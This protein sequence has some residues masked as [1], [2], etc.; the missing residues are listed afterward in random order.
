MALNSKLLT[1]SGNIEILDD[2]Q[3]VVRKLYGLEEQELDA[4]RIRTQLESIIAQLGILILSLQQEEN[5]FL[6][7]LGYGTGE[8]GK[9]EF[10]EA[11]KAFYQTKA[12]RFYGP[13]VRDIIQGYEA[14]SKSRQQETANYF[15]TL[16]EQICGKKVAKVIDGNILEIEGIA[17]D[18][19]IDSFLNELNIATGR[20][21]S[22][23]RGSGSL[24]GSGFVEEVNKD[25]TRFLLNK[26]SPTVKDITNEAIKG[27]KQGNNKN[28]IL[29]QNQ[30]ADK[31]KSSIT[32]DSNN[33]LI[34]LGFEWASLTG[35]ATSSNF[36][37]DL[38]DTNKKIIAQIARAIAKDG[39]EEKIAIEVMES[40]FLSNSNKDDL[41][42]VGQGTTLITGILG[43]IAAVLAIYNL[44]KGNIN[45]KDALGWVATEKNKGKQLSVDMVLKYQGHPIGIQVKNTTKDVNLIHNDILEIGFAQGQLRGN[46]SI[47]K[48]LG[49]ND[50]DE[51]SI[52]SALES[53][54]FN[55][56]YKLEGKTYV[57]TPRS[58]TLHHGV[59]NAANFK[60][61]VDID[62]EIQKVAEQI[63]LF[64]QQFMPDF[65]YMSLGEDATNKLAK[66]EE[67]TK[68]TAARI[69]GNAVYMVADRVAFASDMIQTFQQDLQ[70]LKD[71]YKDNE[72]NTQ[73]MH[74]KLQTSFKQS[75][76]NGLSLENIVEYLNRHG[77]DS[78]S[79]ASYNSRLKSSW[80]FDR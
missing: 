48:K 20:S 22:R 70:I 26:L 43:E 18:K 38:Q 27:I 77:R 78:T 64:F 37:G 56:P 55:V 54:T 51:E 76:K 33:D 74:L 49:F 67:E 79:L 21:T 7:A 1:L 80:G 30:S 9:K 4:Q 2:S 36:S 42:L 68:E 31:L 72:I 75:G 50:G 59:D 13:N 15:S 17:A 16:L 12:R 53:D 58:T 41:F 8:S 71:A 66:L 5:N 14:G 47:L 40:K 24:Y 28:N 34:K 32:I 10:K 23:K 65:L 60:R 69:K 57:Q 39:I 73:T 52:A 45:I 35:G 46:E 44:F 63:H 61:F 11:V 25:T 6:T 19:V 62:F 3:A 29:Y